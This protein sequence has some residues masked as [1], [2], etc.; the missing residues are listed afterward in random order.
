M[1]END[2]DRRAADGQRSDQQSNRDWELDVDREPPAGPDRPSST[3]LDP[4]LAGVL[5][6]LLGILSGVAFLVIE[7]DSAF[8]RFHALQSTL[9]FGALIVAQVVVRWIP[10]LGSILGFLLTLVG[11]VLWLHLMYRAYQGQWYKLP[12]I[13]DLV[14]DQLG[15]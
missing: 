1:D 12:Y 3:G 2:H 4:K 7:K 11:I 13:G 14:E 6:Y 9:T 15:S 8:V 10:V 5:C